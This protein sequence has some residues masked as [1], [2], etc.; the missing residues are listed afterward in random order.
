MLG[1]LLFTEGDPVAGRLRARVHSEYWRVRDP[2]ADL[3]TS[4]AL[5]KR[6]GHE[7]T[8]GDMKGHDLT[9]TGTR[10]ASCSGRAGSSDPGW[11]RRPP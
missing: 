10:S 6:N 5:T 8:G 2:R 4:E 11:R 3:L 9:R 7:G 1:L